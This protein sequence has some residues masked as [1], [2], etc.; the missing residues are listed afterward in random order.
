M[1]DHDYKFLCSRHTCKKSFTSKSALDKHSVT[2]KPPCFMCS[3]CSKE[4]FQKYQMESHKNVHDLNKEFRCLYSRCNHMYKS[5][6]EYNHYYRS[7]CREYEEFQAR[8][9]TK[10]LQK[11]RTWTST[12]NSIAIALR[13]SAKHVGKDS[14]GGV[15]SGCTSR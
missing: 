13:R 14:T 4:F 9:V 6:G 11:K 2:H 15:A 8:I 3:M 5:Q 10:L 1:E 7:H 12:W